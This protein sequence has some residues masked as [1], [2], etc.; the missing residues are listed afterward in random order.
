MSRHRAV[1][2][3]VVQPRLAR[4]AL[5]GGLAAAGLSACV[6]V[7]TRGPIEQVS[8]SSPLPVERGVQVRPVPPQ[9][10]A[11]PEVVLAGFLDAMA[12]L[13]SGFG[14]ARQYLTSAAAAGWHPNVGVTVFDGDRRTSQVSD[15]SAALEAPLVG[16]LDRSGHFTSATGTL[17]HDFG[18]TKV[19]GQWRIGN[20]PKGLLVSSYTLRHRFTPAQLW[21][22]DLTGA[23]VVPEQ[24]WLAAFPATPTQLVQALLAGPSDWLRP[25]VATAI[26]ADV[27]LAAPAV[28]V[29]EHGLAEVALSD[30]IDSLPETQR[31]QVMAQLALTL[32]QLLPVLRVV[33][34]A[35][36][37]PWS[38]PGV[39]PVLGAGPQE[40]SGFLPVT[41][42]AAPRP[43]VVVDGTVRWYDEPD[44][45]TPVAGA[46]GQD[47][48][49]PAQLVAA[50]MSTSTLAVVGK[51]RAKLWLA[52]VDAGEAATVLSGTQLGRP[53]FDGQGRLWVSGGTPATLSI[54]DVDRTVR[55]VDLRLPTGHAL[56]AF[57]LSPSGHLLTVVTQA[58][59]RRLLGQLVVHGDQKI[60]A[61]G[62][63]QLPLD[64]S[65][66]AH[67][68]V[69]DVAWTSPSQLLVLAATGAATRATGFLLSPDGTRQTAVGP[70]GDAEPVALAVH[71]TMTQVAATM[72]TSR[73]RVLRHEAAWRW[74][75]LPVEVTHF[76]YPR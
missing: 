17:R 23:R 64:D 6:Q 43:L 40:F 65:Q 16:R 7:P 59:K 48:P 61:D 67:D 34:R 3:R 52:G 10:G 46:F 31:S 36:G 8:G 54:V 32:G 55:P 13:E 12:S 19:A 20:P 42:D 9:P 14:V 18:M 71:P 44:Q 30:P 73:K 58:G 25:A 24:V 2:P 69:I 11:S 74:S 5:L 39:D 75:E 28:T 26:P 45:L 1:Q 41:Q 51:S 37:K 62:Y 68:W 76:A 27:R 33:V 72:L 15:D 47:A 56:V 50:N 60:V 4:R 21:F 57:C 53:Q 49:E 35:G 38:V 29:D 70:T 63:R 22:L 66:R